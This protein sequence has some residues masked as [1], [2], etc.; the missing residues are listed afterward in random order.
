MA[1]NTTE[2]TNLYNSLF[3]SMVAK[4]DDMWAANEIDAETYA[5]LVGQASS[6]LIAL[7]AELVQKQEALDVD[8]QLKLK[9][10]EIADKELD[11]KISELGRLRDTT[12]AEL[13]KNWGY[14]VTRD[15]EGNL[16]FGASTGLG[17]VDEEIGLLQ[18]QDKVA[19]TEQ[20][21]KDKQA[22]Q[23]GLD[24]VVK[25]ANAT[26]EAVYTPKYVE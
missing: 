22:A 17:K 10:L 12:E 23:L 9:Q 24:E 6:Q 19:L 11:I 25:T 7:S 1:I 5:Q 15:V 4:Y 18:T 21:I 16:V 20:V 3:T 14:E 26:P 8:N 2:I 13:E